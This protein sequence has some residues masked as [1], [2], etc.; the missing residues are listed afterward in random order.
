MEP[1]LRPA[2]SPVDPA[3]KKKEQR[4]KRQQTVYATFD[5]EFCETRN[6]QFTGVDL[7][8]AQGGPDLLVSAEAASPGPRT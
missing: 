5:T 8:V 1:R 6:W 2:W 4:K 7:A 3:R